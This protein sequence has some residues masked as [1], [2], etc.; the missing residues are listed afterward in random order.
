MSEDALPHL[1]DAKAHSDERR[2][3]QKHQILV[4]LMRRNPGAFIIDSDDGKGIV[5]VTHVP[6]GFQMHAPKQI[7]PRQ[8]EIKRHQAS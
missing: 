1:L 5:G 6:T 4:M 7:V 3:S 2:Y 8:V